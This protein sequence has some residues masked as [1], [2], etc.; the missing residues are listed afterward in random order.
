MK[1]AILCIIIFA[2]LV[3]LA[4]GSYLYI[5]DST[6]ELLNKVEFVAYS[7]VNGDYGAVFA[8]AQDAEE[9][10]KDFRKRRFLIIDRDN[11][12]ELTASLA[13][14]RKLSEDIPQTVSERGGQELLVECAVAKA[15]LQQY[16]ENQKVNL[17]NIL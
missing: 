4:A 14:I 16:L 15:L 3:A 10:W 7:F 5:A 12:A 8:A 17:Y 2:A 6:A 9:M 13:R 11:V 1:R